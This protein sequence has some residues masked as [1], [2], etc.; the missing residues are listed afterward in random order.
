MLSPNK[1]SLCSFLSTVQSQK[2]VEMQGYKQRLIKTLMQL[3]RDF[4]VLKLIGILECLMAMDHMDIWH[5]NMH[6]NP[7]LKEYQL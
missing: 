1:R 2:Q 7:Y 6:Q 4:V 3:L 5:Q